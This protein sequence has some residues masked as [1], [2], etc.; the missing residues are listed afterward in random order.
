MKRDWLIL[1]LWIFIFILIRSIHF[2]AGL[3]FSQDQAA[4]SLRGLELLREGKITL[5]GTHTGF[6]FQGR[7]LFQGPLFIYTYMAYNL[8]GRFDP[9]VSSYI[10]MLTGA[11]GIIPLYFGM[12]RLAGQSVGLLAV[13]LYTMVPYFINYTKFMWNPNFQFI[14]T[15]T[16]IYFFARCNAKKSLAW[17]LATSIMAGIL[18]QD[19]YQYVVVIA[20]L[21]V[22]LLSQR[23]RFK[24]VV[25]FGSGLAIG[26]S[27]VILFEIRNGFYNLN[28]VILYLQHFNEVFIKNDSGPVSP[29]FFLSISLVA[30]C[31]I[32]VLLKKYIKKSY[33]I[34]TIILLLP[35]SAQYLK[36]PDR[37]YNSS[38]PWK[39]EDE[40]RVYNLVKNF[41][42]KDKN[43]SHLDY[44][45][46]AVVQKYFLARDKKPFFDDYY[47][48]KYLFAVSKTG[49]LDSYKAYEISRF[50]PRTT[51]QSWPINPIYTLYLLERTN[52]PL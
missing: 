50:S 4:D 51:V 18:L 11:L 26:F 33:V 38:I 23:E 19:H 1:A 45:N 28:T 47:K 24:S 17:L 46:I 8:L 12:K 5:I 25:A 36:I 44:D 29:H 16:L 15:P 3:N 42:L 39:F 27:P 37:M 35:F 20:A 48:N 32:L 30:I 31:T 7:L 52:K 6:N 40:L 13:V 22:Y 9:I 10:F 43:I 34:I 2:T 21:G 14:L 49:K 41:D